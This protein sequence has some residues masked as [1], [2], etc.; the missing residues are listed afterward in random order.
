MTAATCSGVYS[1]STGLWSTGVDRGRGGT[2]FGL[3]VDDPEAEAVADPDANEEALPDPGFGELF[4]LLG[5]EALV[6]IEGVAPDLS[7]SLSTL[8]RNALASGVG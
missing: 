5:V 1:L 4:V 2:D 7:S 6:D 8:A 3:A